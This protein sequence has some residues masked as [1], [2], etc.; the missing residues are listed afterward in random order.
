MRALITGINGFVGG[1][2]AEHLLEVGGWEVW[3][4]ARSAAVNLPALVGHVQ[5]VQ[6]D[7]ADPA[8]VAR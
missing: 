1:H 6:A 7:L 3:G 2:L 5:M 8:A 4:L